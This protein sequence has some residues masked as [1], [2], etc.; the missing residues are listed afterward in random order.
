MVDDDV[1]DPPDP[2]GPSEDPDALL[3]GYGRALADAVD[4]ALPAWVDRSV[5][6]VAGAQ[7][8]AL[9]AAA[10]ASLRAAGE[11]ARADGVTRLRELLA[12][13]VDR[14][15][16]SPLAILRSLVRYP[17][18]VLRSLGARPVARDEFAERSFP[19]DVYDLSP[20]AFADV[21]PALHEPGMAWGAA[22]AYT[23]LHRRR[24]QAG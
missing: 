18:E 12:A 14:Q 9:D 3:A 21:D 6:R 5:R 11:A 4:A 20:A 23:H 16:G 1:P 17:T 15:V 24:G 2:S 7:G 10:E 8:L 19:D 13:D 22:K